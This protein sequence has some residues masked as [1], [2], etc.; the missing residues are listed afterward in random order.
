[1]KDSERCEQEFVKKYIETN[2]Q[3]YEAWKEAGGCATVIEEVTKEYEKELHEQAREKAIAA[4][5]NPKN[6]GDWCAY[7]NQP[8]TRRRPNKTTETQNKRVC[9]MN[10]WDEIAK[11][12]RGYDAKSK[13]T[14]SKKNNDK[15]NQSNNTMDKIKPESNKSNDKENDDSNKNDSN[16]NDS[17]NKAEEDIEEDIDIHIDNMDVKDDSEMTNLLP[18]VLPIQLSVWMHVLRMCILK[19]IP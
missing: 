16:E 3:I 1:M 9:K 8:R 15:N 4:L 5:K 2:L 10:Q 11:A 13:G 7:W 19:C 17:N 18:T 14:T 6:Q 12:C